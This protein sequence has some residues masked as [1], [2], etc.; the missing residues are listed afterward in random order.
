MSREPRAKAQCKG[1]GLRGRTR[2]NPET[3]MCRECYRKLLA[4]AAAADHELKGGRWVQD[5]W[6]QRWVRDGVAS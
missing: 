1:C 5:G 6:I 2:T 4:Q 3:Y